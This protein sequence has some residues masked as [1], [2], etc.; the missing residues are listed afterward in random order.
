M[1][2]APTLPLSDHHR[3]PQLG[4]GVFKVDPEVAQDVTAQALTA[5]YRHVDTA[6]A[7]RNEEGVG[8]AI[9]ESGL[10]RE[11]VFV[12]TKLW[13]DAHDHDDALAAFDDSL[14]RLGLEY[15]DLYLVHWAKPSQGKHVEAWKALIELQQQGRV[16]SIGVSNYP[17]PQLEEAIEATGVVPAVHQ[18]ELHPYFQQH[19][20]RSLHAEHGITT[21][22]W[23]PLGQGKQGLLEDPTLVR[24]AHEHDATPAQVVLA[25]HLAEGIVALPKSV[26]PSRIVENLEST[27]LELGEEDLASIRALDR[28]DGRGG[29]DPA[30][31]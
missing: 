17:R 11:D 31:R 26:T 25:W 10:P 28:P 9:R 15:V 6:A 14:G 30:T 1:S 21:E 12:T 29:A 3:I 19:D 7:Y 16:R 22:A 24:I 2:P 18:I 20:L 13:D 8:A 27:Q 4:Y 5:G 23:G